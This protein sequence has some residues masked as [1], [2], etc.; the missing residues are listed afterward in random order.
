MDSNQFDFHIKNLSLHA[1]KSALAKLLAG[2][3]IVVHHDPTMPTAAFDIENRVLKVPMWKNISNELYDFLLGHETSHALW[4]PKTWGDDITRV[5]EKYNTK[6]G[7]I[8][9]YFNIIED[10]RIDKLMKRKFP[11]LKRDY[12]IG[13]K[14]LFDRDFFGIEKRRREENKEIKDYFF[15]D[16]VNIYFKAGTHIEVPFS[17]EEQAL[18][19]DIAKATTWKHVNDLVE[20]AWE[21]SKKEIEEYEEEQK[22]KG[23]EQGDGEGDGEG[24]GE[25]RGQR[26]GGTIKVRRDG[27]REKMDSDGQSEEG[28]GEG[29]SEAQSQGKG[30]GEGDDEEG[31]ALTEFDHIV[32]EEN[33]DEDLG[34][35]GDKD[36]SGKSGNLGGSIGGR[37]A[38]VGCTQSDWDEN[39]MKSIV[40]YDTIKIDYF[41]FPSINKNWQDHVKDVKEVR[42][43]REQQFANSRGRNTKTDQDI[44]FNKQNIWY[45]Q[46]KQTV[47][48]MVNIFERYKSA[49]EYLRTQHAKTGVLNMNKVYGYKFKDDLFL[50]KEIH[51][52]GKN[53]G[54]VFFLDWSGSMHGQIEGTVKQ[55]ALLCM[56]C[57]QINVPFEVYSFHS[58]NYQERY[59]A[60]G[61][62]DYV[63]NDIEFNQSFLLKNIMSS[64][65]NSRDFLSSLKMAMHPNT[66]SFDGLGGTPL[67]STILAA[68]GVVT[69]FLTRTKV[70]QLNVIFLTDG[71]SETS[72]GIHGVERDKYNSNWQTRHKSS[73]LII[74][75]NTNYV[76]PTGT[77]ET[78][79][80]LRTLKSRLTRKFDKKDINVVGF[81]LAGNDTYY[82]RK[83]MDTKARELALKSWTEFGFVRESNHD[84][85]DEHYVL[86]P[87]FF[88]ND[89]TN[90]AKMSEKSYNS[91]E[92]VRQAATSLYNSKR[93]Q[94][95]LIDNYMK[96]LCDFG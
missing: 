70:Q 18:V 12:N 89:Q 54:F 26:R 60:D 57:R 31:I 35:D 93:S 59:V 22:Q 78:D 69:E 67:N 74:D 75:K 49:D 5:A 51:P 10:A 34:E 4:T 73:S 40:H 82:N 44:L 11:G 24:E 33:L 87:R 41:S 3:N 79:A 80:L 2:E 25:G 36:G 52:T 19:D 47:A 32:L 65:E 39:M 90:T 66:T 85:Y 62:F 23:E 21:L 6:K 27:K 68:E 56:F 83:E 91:E 8:K 46:A 96:K 55:L 88:A 43:W 86:N 1:S 92:A 7:Y 76:I 17:A 42:T 53:H 72:T 94:R 63:N 95:M 13:Y 64:R 9:S 48:Y 81:F 38:P 84:G 14:E 45:N 37:G 28:E 58:G 15:I 29:E 77:N 50:R 30:E 16:R 71:A 61:M 20:R